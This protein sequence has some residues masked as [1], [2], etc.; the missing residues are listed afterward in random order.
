LPLLS[1]YE[2]QVF[3]VSSLRSPLSKEAT[4]LVRH[5]TSGNAQRGFTVQQTQHDK[6]VPAC[7]SLPIRQSCSAARLHQQ[8]AREANLLHLIGRYAVTGDVRPIFLV[9][10]AW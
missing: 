4:L 5:R 8:R 2:N 9:P 3:D 1:R 6:Q 10:L 7:K